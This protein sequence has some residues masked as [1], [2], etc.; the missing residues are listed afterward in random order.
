MHL[1]DKI[2]AAGSLCPPE[3]VHQTSMNCYFAS[4]YGCSRRTGKD[5]DAKN[6][7]SVVIIEGRSQ[8]TP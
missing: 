6:R 4:K 2:T 3:K 8:E 7:I 5:R 1:P